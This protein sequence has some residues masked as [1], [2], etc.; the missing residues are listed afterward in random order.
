MSPTCKA[1][2]MTERREGIKFSYY[3]ILLRNGNVRYE[4]IHIFSK[5]ERMKLLFKVTIL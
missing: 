2:V 5:K 3:F 4:L 1:R